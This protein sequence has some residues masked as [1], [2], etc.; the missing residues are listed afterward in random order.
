MI[1]ILTGKII[2]YQYGLSQNDRTLYFK[3]L[4]KE[5]HWL[6]VSA[7]KLFGYYSGNIKMRNV[8]YV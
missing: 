7:T 2:T 4:N 3:L 5:S 8:N 6:R 1:T